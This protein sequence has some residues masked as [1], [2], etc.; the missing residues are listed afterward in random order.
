MIDYAAF[1][2]LRASAHRK[3]SEPA[4]QENCIAHAAGA[5]G[6]W[7]EPIIGRFWPV[8]APFYN[9]RIDSLVRIFE[10]MGYVLCESAEHEPEYQKIAIYGVG[11]QYTHVARQLQEN[12]TWTSKLGAED[13]INHATLE[14][15]AD[16]EYGRVARI[17]RRR[18]SV[19]GESTCC[20]QERSSPPQQ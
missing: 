5:R 11:D 8:G 20:E 19:R 16:G 6:E 1:P 7:W 17:M 12:G 4:S 13:D 3:T 15:L 18:I 2:N 14:A 9:H 10:R